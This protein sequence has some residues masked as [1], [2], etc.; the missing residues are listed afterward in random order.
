[1]L[2]DDARLKFNRCIAEMRR[3]RLSSADMTADLLAR[4]EAQGLQ[5]TVVPPGALPAVTDRSLLL[6]RAA[7]LETSPKVED[8]V[9][10]LRL[11]LQALG[12]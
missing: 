12:G 2:S 6:R 9:E 1:M 11:R 4:L 8:R 5:I 7:Q 10:G 3:G